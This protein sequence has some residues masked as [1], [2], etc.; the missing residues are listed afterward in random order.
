VGRHTKSSLIEYHTRRDVSP[1]QNRGYRIFG[2]MTGSQL[3]RCHI[4]QTHK[5][6]QVLLRDH[7]C[8]LTQPRHGTEGKEGQCPVSSTTPSYFS[9]FFSAVGKEAEGQWEIMRKDIGCIGATA[10][11]IAPRCNNRGGKAIG[12]CRHGK[13]AQ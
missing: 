7:R 4:P 12:L 13:K 11:F 5:V 2:H 3:H 10:S 1:H 6:L 9:S 8:G